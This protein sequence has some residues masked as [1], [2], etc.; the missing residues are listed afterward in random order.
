MTIRTGPVGRLARLALAAAYAATLLSV[1][2]RRGS[3]H[4]RNPH[5]LTEPLAWFLHLVMFTSF[6]LLVG[7]LASALA[8]RGAMRRWQLGAF[9]ASWLTVGVVA[10]IGRVAFGSVWGFP[11]ADLVWWFDVLMLIEGL[12]A[13]LLAVALGTPGCEIGVW[14][15]LV[16]RARGST[17]QTEEGLACIVGLHL[18]DQWEA[19]RGTLVPGEGFEP[20]VEDPKSSA[21]PLGHPGKS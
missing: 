2:D 14:P 18:I 11:L 16:A 15:E 9:V 4:F 5:I 8:G 20:S 6:L 12:V 17:A 3:A 7:A 21:L 10:A 13:T 1:V 19:R